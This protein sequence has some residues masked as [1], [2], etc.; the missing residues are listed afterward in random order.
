MKLIGRGP[1]VARNLDNQT[2]SGVHYAQ[3]NDM[4]AI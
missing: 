2:Y 1:V 4:A 3:K